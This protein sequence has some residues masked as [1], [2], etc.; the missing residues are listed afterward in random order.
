MSTLVP[1]R[2]AKLV[3]R[4]RREVDEGRVPGCQ[5][6]IGFEGEV[7]L[8]EA[9]GDL[10]TSH[11][12]HTYSA[13]K[14]TVSLT[15]LVLAAEG[16]LDLEAP[17]A[18]VL[19]PF[20]T[21]GKAAITISQVLLHAGGFPHAPIGVAEFTD[22]PARLARYEKWRTTW[23]PGSAFEYHASAGHWVLADC[24]TE[25]TGRHHADVVT[26]RVM[27][28]AGCSRWLA[29]PESEQGDVAAVVSVGEAPDLEAFARQFGIDEMP[30][31]E[32]T[33]EALL[34]FN[35]PEIRAAGHPGGGGIASAAEMALWY[36]A[37]MHD[38]GEILRPEVKEDALRVVRQNHADWLGVSAN[39]TRVFTIGGDDG[40]ALMRGYGHTT[41]PD[42]FG[43]GG[44]KGQRAW[45]DPRTGVSLGFMTHGLDRDD[46]VVARRGAGV[47]SAAGAVTT[48]MD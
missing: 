4:C 21:N 32:V 45:A 47:S 37:V 42:T 8:F 3:D 22:R 31:T 36:Q 16:L 20:A 35:D 5:V 17:V 11:R 23:E 18:S 28:P 13:V 44:A 33:D 1:Q 7:V 24:I 29:I 2:M 10:T 41:G 46:L 48:P 25:V 9:F 15:V 6:A 38:D 34:A 39:R 43:H 30:V 19:P 40:Q 26:E 27:T 12:I 14:P